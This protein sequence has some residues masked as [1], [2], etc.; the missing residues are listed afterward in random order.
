MT[1][2]FLR[3]VMCVFLFMSFWFSPVSAGV[4]REKLLTDA[5]VY[6]SFAVFALDDQ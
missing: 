1:R 5:G 2:L 3:T 4:D 6:G